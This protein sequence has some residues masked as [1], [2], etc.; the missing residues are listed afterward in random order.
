MR[1]IVIAIT[2]NKKTILFPCGGLRGA[3]LMIEILQKSK[4]I[5]AELKNGSYYKYVWLGNDNFAKLFEN[6]NYESNKGKYKGLLEFDEKI[7]YYFDYDEFN[8]EKEIIGIDVE[9]GLEDAEIID[10]T[11]ENINWDIN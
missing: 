3:R 6:W 8:N 2:V 10:F 7:S 4:I 11:I 9:D 5:H 1:W